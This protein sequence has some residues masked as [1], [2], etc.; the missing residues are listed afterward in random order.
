MLT[1]AAGTRAPLYA[2]IR[3]WRI[4]PVVEAVAARLAQ[5]GTRAWLVG[6]AVRDALLGR[7][8]HD[9]DVAVDGKAHLIGRRIAD[10]LGGS[11]VP[12]D[13]DRDIVRVALPL[14]EANCFVDFTS[15]A[16]GIAADLSRRDFTI[17]AM[18]VP[19]E[20]SLPPHSGKVRACPRESGGWEALL[21]PHAGQADLRAATIRAVSPGVFADDPARLARAPRLAAQ[22]GFR[23]HADT[24]A[25]IRAGAH[26]IAN[27]APERVTHELMTLLAHP[28]AMPAVR[29]L[30]QL[31]LLCRI[32][33]ELADAKGVTQPREHYYDVFN[34]LVEAVGQL[35][36]IMLGERGRGD[37]VVDALPSVEGV[38]ERFAETIGNGHD[39]LTHLKLA[40]LLHDVA[41]PATRT[42]E[43]TGRIRFLGHHTEGE[44]MAG[45]IA[46]RLRLS[47]RGATLISQIV[48]HHL[49]PGQLG[50][51]GALP[52]RRA[53]YRFFRDAGDA[54]ID[55]IY[56]NLA[57]FLAARGPLL[58]REEWEHACRVAKMMLE[59]G[60]EWRMGD[61]PEK[62]FSTLLNGHD[63]MDAYQLAPGPTVG[64]MLAQVAEAAASG[65]VETKEEALALVGARLQAGGRRA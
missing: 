40:A 54:A 38:A 29:L 1:Q 49:R 20:E 15:A 35:E 3:E 22:L 51:E 31:G 23:I 63:I 5:H 10:E 28:N 16:D 41:K 26:L 47:G 62:P 42:V 21:D 24:Q 12:W 52:T 9:I 44:A 11:F 57:D 8:A 39:R 60:T 45:A 32:L 61:A 33:P 55:T 4:A 19:L 14:G 59:W 25:R 6:G 7:E 30:D 56:V 65:D 46:R 18:A 53:M 58:Y 27:V 37:W 13:Y 64:R 48:R 43:D 2:P 34:H 17:N 50:R 36:R